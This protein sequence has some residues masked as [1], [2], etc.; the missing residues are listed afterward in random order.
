[1]PLTLDTR[2]GGDGLGGQRG[3]ERGAGIA[4]HGLA[5]R[6]EDALEVELQQRLEPAVQPR[7]VGVADAGLVPDPQAALGA[8][9]PV[10]RKSVV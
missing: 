5:V 6:G 4:Q 7:A 8:D 10:D 1:M 9:D 2:R 3:L